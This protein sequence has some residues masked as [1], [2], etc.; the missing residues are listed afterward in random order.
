[1]P[2]TA[3]PALAARF[4]PLTEHFAYEFDV[5]RQEDRVVR[6]RA[7]LHEAD[8][9]LRRLLTDAGAADAEL[10]LLDLHGLRAREAKDAL[11]T[12]TEP[13]SVVWFGKGSGVLREVFLEFLDARD[14]LVLVD[15]SGE[16]R[17]RPQ[18]A[19][20]LVLR[21]DLHRRLEA[22]IAKP[23]PETKPAPQP[24]PPKTPQTTPQPKPPAPAPGL[25]DLLLRVFRAIFD[26][27]RR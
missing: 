16:T 2:R 26:L 11:R 14:D 15:M 23:A 12:C 10:Q 9:D 6:L 17:E 19:V 18:E 5:D 20:G 27:L 1:M 21:A 3:S 24:R 25:L 4:L 7:L 22:A 13:L 8:P